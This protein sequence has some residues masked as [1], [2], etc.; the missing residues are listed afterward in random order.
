MGATPKEMARAKHMITNNKEERKKQRAR[1]FYI[2]RNVR[3][4]KIFSLKDGGEAEIQCDTRCWRGQVSRPQ[5]YTAQ[6]SHEDYF[7]G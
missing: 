6:V 5:K 4:E 1:Y 2:T 3:K 7:A